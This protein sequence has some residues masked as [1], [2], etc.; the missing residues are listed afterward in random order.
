[1]RS[2]RA[3]ESATE[4][5][6]SAA[7]FAIAARHHTAADLIPES[8]SSTRSQRAGSALRSTARAAMSADLLTEAWRRKRAA[9]SSD[10]VAPVATAST[11]AAT[12]SSSTI[13]SCSFVD[14]RP[15]RPSAT[16]AFSRTAGAWS[17]TSG[18]MSLSRW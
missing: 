11:V 14:I 8:E 17:E 7:W 18:R 3:P 9:F 2:V 10:G 13:S 16:M 1:M 4:E 5:A 6:R 12:V 15:R